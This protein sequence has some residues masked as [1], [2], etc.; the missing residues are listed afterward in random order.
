MYQ[1]FCCVDCYMSV[2]RI[3]LTHRI[4]VISVVN[5]LLYNNSFRNVKS[6]K[7][8]PFIPYDIEAKKNQVGIENTELRKKIV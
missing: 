1:Q 4:H 5:K 2:K 3:A 8:S 7:A 6:A